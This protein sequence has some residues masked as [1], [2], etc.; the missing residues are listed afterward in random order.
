MG[1]DQEQER[2]IRSSR[3]CTA[4]V[5]HIAFSR[6]GKECLDRLT[7]HVMTDAALVDAVRLGQPGAFEAIDRHYRSRLTKFLLQRTGCA[8][9]AEEIVQRSLVKAFQSL[10]RLVCGERLGAWLYRI[11][12][13]QWIDEHRRRRPV[14]L[15]THEPA[16][17]TTAPE[18]RLVHRES[19]DNLWDA[20]RRHLSEDEYSALWLRYA[21]ELTDREIAVVLGKSHGAVRVL[22]CRARRTLARTVADS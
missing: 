19:C 15:G 1:D 14:S 12:L 11:A 10:D 4:W 13:R 18:T 20:A 6:F 5:Y 8:D 3:F 16:T 2:L 21:E 17:E 7:D 9:T 22:L